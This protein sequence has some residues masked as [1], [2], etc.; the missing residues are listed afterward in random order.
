MDCWE[1][2]ESDKFLLGDVGK[3][4]QIKDSKGVKVLD[5]E[6]KSSK[7]DK[8]KRFYI[9]TFSESNLKSDCRPPHKVAH[10]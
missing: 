3:K 5:G 4:E 10:K 7:G 6:G 9:F 8:K 1:A 2:S